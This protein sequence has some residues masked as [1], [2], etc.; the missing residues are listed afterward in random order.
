MCVRIVVAVAWFLWR[1]RMRTSEVDVLRSKVAKQRG[2]IMRLE[3]VVARLAADKAELLLD[4]KM[5]KAE[6][7]RADGKVG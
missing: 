5:Y 7:E 3:Q 2:E 6:L 1:M 4:V